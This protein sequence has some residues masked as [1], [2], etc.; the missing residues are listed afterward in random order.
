MAATWSL[1][2]GRHWPTARA[3]AQEYLAFLFLVLLAVIRS[4]AAHACAPVCVW[5]G[6]PGIIFFATF[7]VLTIRSYPYLLLLRHRGCAPAWRISPTRSMFS[8]Y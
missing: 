8:L 7:L 6:V 2:L 5:I 1:L 4:P 3:S